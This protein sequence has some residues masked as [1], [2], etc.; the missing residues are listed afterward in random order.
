MKLKQNHVAALDAMISHF[1]ARIRKNNVLREKI[2]ADRNNIDNMAGKYNFYM[3]TN[4]QLATHCDDS[5]PKVRINV[6]LKI[7]EVGEISS[8]VELTTHEREL[9]ERV[10]SG[11]DYFDDKGQYSNVMKEMHD[12]LQTLAMDNNSGMRP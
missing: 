10:F 1:E 11:L 4:C 5:W 9:L 7:K 2:E 12:T 8:A 3:N 6:L